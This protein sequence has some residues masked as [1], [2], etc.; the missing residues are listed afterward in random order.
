MTDKAKNPNSAISTKGKS[1]HLSTKAEQLEWL[2][3]K[4]IEM[5]REA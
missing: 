1:R 2:R 5:S 4:V 3:A